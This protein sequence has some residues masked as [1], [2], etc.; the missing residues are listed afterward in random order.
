V[1]WGCISLQNP[2]L[3]DLYDRIEVGTLIVILP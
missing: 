1:T 3:E 2:D